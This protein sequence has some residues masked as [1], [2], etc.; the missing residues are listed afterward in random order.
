MSALDDVLAANE[1]FASAF[2]AGDLPAPPGS[3]LAVLTCMDARILPLGVFG[4]ELGDAHVLRN[5]GGRV[6]DDVLRSLLVSTHVLGVRAIAVVHHT[7][8]GMR[9]TTDDELRAKVTEATGHSP[10]DLEFHAVTDADADLRSDVERLT[11][12]GLLPAGTD[13]RGYE[14]DVQTGRL[15]QVV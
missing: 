8:C 15:R 1:R 5:A 10:G 4:L 6:T 7:L 12:S 3:H 13:V 14:Y 9:A 11:Q 2:T